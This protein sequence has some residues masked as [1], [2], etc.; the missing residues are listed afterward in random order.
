MSWI[1]RILPSVS[2][3]LEI[4]MLKGLERFGRFVETMPQMRGNPFP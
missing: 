2:L 1:D 3:D 4:E